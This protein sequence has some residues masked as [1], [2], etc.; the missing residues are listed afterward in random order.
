MCNVHHR[1]WGF[2]VICKQNQLTK[3]KYILFRRRFSLNI[4]P[5]QNQ[6]IILKKL[7]RRDMNSGHLNT[8]DIQIA[9]FQMLGSYN[10]TIK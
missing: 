10:L 8:C 2:S 6:I 9:D 4:Y 1:K 3:Q 5:A 7:K